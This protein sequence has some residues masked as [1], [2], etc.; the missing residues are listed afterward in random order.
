MRP[1][2]LEQTITAN[3]NAIGLQAFIDHA[4]KLTRSDSGLTATNRF[5]LIDNPLIPEFELKGLF[6]LLIIRL[7]RPINR[8]A[9]ARERIF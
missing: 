7:A 5:D 2:Q 9:Q 1:Q 6:R 4:M 8:F 3:L